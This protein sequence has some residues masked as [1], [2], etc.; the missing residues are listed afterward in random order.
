MTK[1]QWCILI[2]GLY[3]KY[4]FKNGAQTDY[5]NRVLFLGN[6]LEMDINQFYNE[7]NDKLVDTD[8]NNGH[9]M[10]AQQVLKSINKSEFVESYRRVFKE[11]SEILIEE[12][13]EISDLMYFYNLIKSEP[14]FQIFNQYKSSGAINSFF[15]SRLKNVIKNKL[16]NYI[17]S[18]KQ[19]II[20]GAPGTGK[21]YGVNQEVKKNHINHER[22]TFYSDYEYHN[23]I[24]SI[25]PKL[26][27]ETVT[28]E[29]V[30]G[31]FTKLL[32]DALSNPEDKH[33]LIVEELT[34]GNA[35]AIF[36]DIF[37][38]LDRDEEG[39]S[40]YPITHNNILESLDP[41]VRTFLETEYG[42]KIVLPP[43]L[44]IICTI[45]SS[46]QNV[47]PLDTAFKRRFDYEI[48]S[49]VV[50][51]AKFEKF[52]VHIGKEGDDYAFSIDWIEFQ[53]RLNGFILVNLKLKEDKQVGPYFI[54]NY[55]KNNDKVELIQTKLAMYLWNDLHKVHTISDQSIFNDNVQTLSKV[56]E[57][58]RKGTK[59]E[60]SNILTSQ[61]K[62][63][64]LA[65]DN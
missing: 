16:V 51:K 25:L 40:E 18:Y 26:N 24:G 59:E 27:G 20:D 63:C 56:D 34:R 58:F 21:S 10:N 64:I 57:L 31:P 50:D 44:S 17:K 30:K 54:K 12:E 42:S 28:Y 62:T 47:Y 45:N 11:M 35:A 41:E 48:K 23:F 2:E 7:L 5:K 9:W 37:Q 43:N 6:I 46:D 60:I 52:K 65:K 49:T 61:F 13:S 39:W 38:L 15:N 3:T 55:K 4:D 1:K 19:L 14:F 36:G 33:Y 29:F 53:K 32:N 8:I 22:V